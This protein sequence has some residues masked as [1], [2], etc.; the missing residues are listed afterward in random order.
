MISKGTPPPPPEP[1]EPG[2]L[3]SQHGDTRYVVEGTCMPT[4]T[5]IPIG[6]IFSVKIRKPKP[7]NP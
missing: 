1:T 2:Q 5:T 7:P 6:G 4:G 3:P